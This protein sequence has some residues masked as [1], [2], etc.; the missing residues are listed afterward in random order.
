MKR[1]GT[2]VAGMLAALLLSFWLTAG[3]AQTTPSLPPEAQMAFERG[4]AAA[5]QQEWGV[6]IRYFS[7]ANRS[8]QESPAILF[9][10]GLAHGKAG[11][12]VAAMAWLIAYLAGGPQAPNAAAVRAEIARLDVVAEAKVRRIMAEATAAARKL[13]DFPRRYLLGDLAFVLACTGDIHGAQT[14]AR[15]AKLILSLDQWELWLN[16]ASRLAEEGNIAEAETLNNKFGPRASGELFK[17]KG[18]SGG[19][20]DLDA[21]SSLSAAKSELRRRADLTLIISLAR[22][23]SENDVAVRLEEELKQAAALAR[24]IPFPGVPGG[25]WSDISERLWSVGRRLDIILA[26][27]RAA[28]RSQPR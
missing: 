25:G 13:P 7:Q 4:L 15:E 5:Q 28:W 14:V 21:R 23:V 24:F 3:V 19:P 1:S 27:T 17:D 9:N 22:E 8:A 11:N 26:G 18:C 20:V 16:Y 12:E 2:L 6:A 10:L